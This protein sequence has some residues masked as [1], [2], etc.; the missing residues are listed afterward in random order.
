MATKVVMPKLGLIMEEGTLVEWL[1][2]EGEEVRKGEP[3][4]LIETDKVVIEIESPA[5]GQLAKIFLREGERAPIGTTI[6]VIA[7]AGEDWSSQIAAPQAAIATKTEIAQAQATVSELRRAER[8]QEEALAVK[9]SPLA[10]RLAHEHGLDL[11]SLR[12]TGPGG[13]ITEAD[14]RAAIE[15]K[16]GDR[17]PSRAEK[18]SPIRR[19]TAERVA[20][21]YS[22]VPQ[23][24]ASITVEASALIAAREAIIERAPAGT[25]RPTHTDLIIKEVACALKLFPEVNAYFEADSICYYE[26]INL[27]LAVDAPQGLIVPVIKGVEAKDIFEIARERRSLVEKARSGKLRPEEVSGATFTLSNLGPLGVDSFA[28]IVSSGQAAILAMGR[29]AQRP[30]AINGKLTIAPQFDLTLSSD[31]RIV[32]GAT[33]ARFLSALKEA[34]EKLS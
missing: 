5:S 13:R 15:A 14:V 6:G 16:R 4:M 28:A 11:P 21:S 18:L 34:I 17:P 30:A 25:E 8:A 10:R 32:D 1:K 33:A 3:L 24:H 26:T 29:I 2:R 19:R 9:A 22:A 23:F 12:G 31:H 27:G 7:E 20:A